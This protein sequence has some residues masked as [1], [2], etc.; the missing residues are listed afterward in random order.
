MRRG[1]DD[2]ATLRVPFRLAGWDGTTLAFD[3]ALGNE[4]TT[5]GAADRFK[6]GTEVCLYER[7]TLSRWRARRTC[8]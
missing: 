6:S 2:R 3:T 8:R 5:R 1:G 7:A 4:G